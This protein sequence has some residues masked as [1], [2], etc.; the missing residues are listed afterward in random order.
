MYLAEVVED[1]LEEDGDGDDDGADGDHGP[2]RRLVQRPRPL[3][4][5]AAA[6]TRSA[7]LRF[8]LAAGC[9]LR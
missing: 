2:R 5:F 7:P 8:L 9:R 3:R 4:A 1:A 6:H